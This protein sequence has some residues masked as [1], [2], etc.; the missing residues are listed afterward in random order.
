MKEYGIIKEYDGYCGTISGINNVDYL[1]L[2]KDILY[3]DVM[4]GDI[5]IFTAETLVVNNETKYI[6]RFVEK[7]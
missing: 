5:V 4:K 2:K 3:K 7:K 1:V 6:A